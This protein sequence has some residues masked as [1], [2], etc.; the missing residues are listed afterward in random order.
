MWETQSV[1]KEYLRLVAPCLCTVVWGISL[2]MMNLWAQMQNYLQENLGEGVF[3][4][5]VAPLRV[6]A[7]STVLRLIAPNAFVAMRVEER[8]RDALE[9]ALSY[10]VAEQNPHASSA[11]LPQIIIVAQ[12]SSATTHSAVP[13]PSTAKQAPVEGVTLAAPT[14]LPLSFSSESSSPAAP[15]CGSAEKTSAE[16]TATASRA[17]KNSAEN[18]QASFLSLLQTQTGDAAKRPLPLPKEVAKRMPQAAAL[19]TLREEERAHAESASYGS[20]SYNAHSSYNGSA[21]TGSSAYASR[22]SAASQHQNAHAEQLGLS[23]SFAHN[24]LTKSQWQYDFDDFVVGSCNQFAFAAAKEVCEQ[25]HSCDSL[26]LSSAAGL[27]KTHLLQAVGSKLATLCNRTAPKIAYLTAEE[28]SSRIVQAIKANDMESFKACYRN[29][30]VLL[31]ED[32]H[33]LRGKERMQG[34]ALATL[35]ALQANGS[36]VVFSSSFAP[37]Q[38][39]DLDSQLTSRFCSGLV[40]NIERP[41]YDTR[42]LIVNAKARKHHVA[43]PESISELL[44]KNICTDIRQIESCLQTLTLRARALNQQLSMELALDVLKNYTSSAKT[45]LE[46]DDIIRHIC[47]A[48]ALSVEQLASKSRRHE[49]VLARNTAFLL[50]RKHTELSL[51]DIGL[52]FKRKHSTVIKGIASLEREIKRETP[53]GLQVK[54]TMQRIE[55]RTQ[56]IA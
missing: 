46:F 24:Y 44:A 35:K 53:T 22:S 5:W 36:K 51:E 9:T 52:R 8:L 10:A 32:V 11:D 12:G 43:L 4:M 6:D 7:D 47:G 21:H 49:L 18:M 34:E 17:H 13:A 2:T 16:K 45:T 14:A 42:R 29:V 33:F 41:T 37:N 19:R 26:F 15:R 31:L 23:L 3:R 20:A 1:R 40:A 39:N 28:F 27:G 54:D 25:S 50:A 48:F 55:S 56:I 30:D 38:L